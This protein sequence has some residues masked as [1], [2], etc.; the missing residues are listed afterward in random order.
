LDA[1]D[2]PFAE[3]S[4]TVLFFKGLGLS[5]PEKRELPEYQIARNRCRM[6]MRLK[7]YLIVI[8]ELISLKGAI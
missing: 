2:V 5:G 3:L 6:E 8:K 1:K 7:R 4:S